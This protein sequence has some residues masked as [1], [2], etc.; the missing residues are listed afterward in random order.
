VASRQV[1]LITG[2]SSGIG[3]SAAL[4]AARRGHQVFASARNRND[5][6]DLE[7]GDLHALSLDVTDG[8]SVRSAIGSV[9]SRA[10]RLD[11]LV[12]NAGYA[13]YGAAEDVSAEEW[14][15]QF[16]VNFFGTLEVTRAALPAL[17]AAG[18]GTIV[19]VS[20]VAGKVP[21]PFAA[22]YCSA[23]HALEALSDALRVE[24][25]PFGIRVAVVEPG[26]TP[27]R[28]TERA[29]SLVA[30]LMSRPGPYRTLYAGAERA[31]DGDFQKG[32]QSAEAVARVIVDVL[33]ASRPRARYPVGAMARALIPLKSVLPER[34]L[35]WMMRRS[36]RI[37]GPESRR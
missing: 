22:P 26:P 6:A 8:A 11:A 27:T 14:R 17:R 35:D 19:M 32:G 23:K 2:C 21:V 25:Y 15:A 18:G 28:F 37:P 16:D 29:R 36:L 33:E 13:Q 12:N 3:R 10:G 20:S 31:M 30:P 5:L 9:L 34:W 24:L 7:R 1:V 4:E